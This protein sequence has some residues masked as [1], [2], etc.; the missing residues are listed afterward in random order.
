MNRVV[1]RGVDVHPFGNQ[2]IDD[3]IV[4]HGGRLGDER[5][6]TVYD[7]DHTA[8]PPMIGAAPQ[9][10][11]ERERSSFRKGKHNRFCLARRHVAQIDAETWPNRHAVRHILGM[12]AQQH[13]V[14]CLH[15]NAVRLK[16]AGFRDRR[17]HV[18]HAQ[19][20]HHGPFMLQPDDKGWQQE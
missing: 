17:R 11:V 12:E 18:D 15:L 13:L 5:G 3:G 8:H 4:F 19:A 7:I 16:A 14:A 9:I 10:A 2:R 1:N 6:V 20:T